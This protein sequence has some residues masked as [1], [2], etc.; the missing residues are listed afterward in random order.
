MKI[1]FMAGESKHSGR[2]DQASQRNALAEAIS[3]SPGI[4]DYAAI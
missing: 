1:F 4:G 3:N 2:E